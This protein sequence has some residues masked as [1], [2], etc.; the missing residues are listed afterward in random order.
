M[1]KSTMEPVITA[2]YGQIYTNR[3][4][5]LYALTPNG[6]VICKVLGIT[7]WLPSVLSKELF[8]INVEAGNLVPYSEQ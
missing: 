4:E 8:G 2:A 5:V 1:R 6:N 3:S 7:S